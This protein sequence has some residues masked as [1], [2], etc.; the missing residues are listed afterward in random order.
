M[1]IGG[2]IFQLADQAFDTDNFP[3]RG[4]GAAGNYFESRLVNFNR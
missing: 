1:G 2:S 3:I 4:S